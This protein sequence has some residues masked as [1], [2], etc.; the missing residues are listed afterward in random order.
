MKCCLLR[1]KKNYLFFFF[2]GLED[3]CIIKGTFSKN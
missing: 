2:F 3:N 1:A